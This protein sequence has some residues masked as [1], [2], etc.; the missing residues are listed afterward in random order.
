MPTRALIFALVA[1]TPPLLVLLILWGRSIPLALPLALALVGLAHAAILL[2]IFVPRLAWLGPV[3]TRFEPA[4]PGARAVWLTIDDG[5]DPRDTSI[6][7]DLLARHGARATFFV[8]GELAA[9]YPE[10]LRRIV[11]AGHTIGNHSQTHPAAFGWCMGPAGLDREV[12]GCN[13]AI[14]AATGAATTLYRPPVG[15]KSP[16]LHPVLRRL[17]MSLVNWSVRAF[18]GVAGY[19][20]EA[21]RDRVLAR[22]HPGAIIVMHQGIQTADGRPLS[23]QAI[24]AVLVGLGERGY[25]CEIPAPDRLR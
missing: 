12:R 5:P 13:A 19:R 10:E 22:V 18:D 20:P 23:P 4:A 1:A 21:V 6:I 2:P 16:A 14:E 25:S 8:K 24:E 15:I 7:L 9:R 11:A 17:G 3:I